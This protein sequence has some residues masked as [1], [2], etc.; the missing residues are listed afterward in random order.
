[1]YLDQIII[2]TVLNFHYPLG[3]A[4]FSEYKEKLKERFQQEEILITGHEL[5][6]F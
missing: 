3:D 2:M 4:F 5:S 1:M 6:V